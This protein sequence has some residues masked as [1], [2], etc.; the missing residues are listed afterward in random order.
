MT[1]VAIQSL[2]T[3]TY[4][5][6]LSLILSCGK[7]TEPPSNLTESNQDGKTELTKR[8]DKTNEVKSQINQV[9]DAIKPASVMLNDLADSIKKEEPTDGK[10]SDEV[11]NVLEVIQKILREATESIVEY[12]P[13]GS[14]KIEKPLRLPDLA[15]EYTC[16]TAKIR[17][18]G[19]REERVETLRLQVI[20]CIEAAGPVELAYIGIDA[21]KRIYS[22][23]HLQKVSE[24]FKTEH[25]IGE[26]CTVLVQ[27][28]AV[29]VNCKPIT[30]FTKDVNIFISPL[31]FLKSDL[32][33][34]SKIQVTARRKL[35][36]KLVVRA[37]LDAT[38]GHK[39]KIE[40]TTKEE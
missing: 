20:G 17:L 18:V 36:Q 14:W 22:D 1:K 37:S 40:V 16:G 11:Q 35:T 10:A 8:I 21:E 23:L 24:L 12:Q 31:Y 25:V 26:N 7:P 2:K 19:K 29:E 4:S 30:V 39:T 9:R 5:L 32:G 34:D 33:V 6:I 15:K 3:V 27:T 28:R 13:D 38:P